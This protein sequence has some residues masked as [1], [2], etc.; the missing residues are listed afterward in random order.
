MLFSFPLQFLIPF[1]LVDLSR[2]PVSDLPSLILRLNPFA[3]I[4]LFPSTKPCTLTPAPMAFLLPPRPSSIS[5]SLTRIDQPGPRSYMQHRTTRIW[6]TAMRNTSRSTSLRRPRSENGKGFGVRVRSPP[7]IP[8]K[9]ALTPIR[10]LNRSTRARSWPGRRARIAS[11][12]RP[13]QNRLLSP[14]PWSSR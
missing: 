6:T 8:V 12:R 10:A 5:E 2:H 11:S 14:T 1:L 7:R 13:S 9:L 3:T 4:S